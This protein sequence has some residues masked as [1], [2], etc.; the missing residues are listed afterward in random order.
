MPIELADIPTNVQ[1]H[2]LGHEREGRAVD[3]QLKTSPIEN[4][5]LVRIV[6][7]EMS[8]NVPIEDV[9]PL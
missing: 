3:W 5:V 8:W 2:H 9:E 4:T 1:F 7:R 6:S